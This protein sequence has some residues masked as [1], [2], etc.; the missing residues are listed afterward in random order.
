MSGASSNIV[1]FQAAKE[2]REAEKYIRDF[3]AQDDTLDFSHLD[4]REPT[5]LEVK[6]FAEAMILPDEAG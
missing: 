5:Y 4:K 6:P 1:D 2:K 3:F